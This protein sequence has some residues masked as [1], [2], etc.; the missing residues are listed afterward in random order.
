MLNDLICAGARRR[1]WRVCR[2][3]ALLALLTA[4][5]VA[6]PAFADG[7]I[8]L[9]GQF[10]DWQ[11]QA[12]ISDPQND[13]LNRRTDIKSFYFATNPDDEVAYFMLERWEAGAMPVDYVLW[14]DTNNNGDYTEVSDRMVE[15]HYTPSQNGFADVYLYN[16]AGTFMRTI[17]EN[18]PWGE[19]GQG[20][21]VEW[22]VSFVDLGI[23]PYQTIRLQPVS[24]QGNRV[25]D[26]TAE[27]Q[28]SP[29]NALGWLLLGSL[30]LLGSVWLFQRRKR[31]AW[32][33]QS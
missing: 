25:S 9:D 33:L 23:A 1:F 19:D 18:A 13:A 27:V 15:V 28:W 21:R 11:G 30:T 8:V 20:A 10:T 31:L 17:A 6:N 12:F 7:P 5:L 4:L 32:L 24:M 2:V 3:S 22:G 26:S 14:V 16:G 29:A